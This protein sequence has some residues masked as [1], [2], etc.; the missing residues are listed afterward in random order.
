MML[1]RQAVIP[2]PATYSTILVGRMGKIH[3]SHV[4]MLTKYFLGSIAVL[5]MFSPKMLANVR[6]VPNVYATIS[7][8]VAAAS[9]G[10]TIRVFAGTYAEHVNVNKSLVL[11][12][13]G[14]Y[15]SPDSSHDDSGS[16]RFSD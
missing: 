14:T 10:D 2:K 1:P 4:Q 6:Y 11:I 12:G 7:A 3:F 13:S 5:A 8:A 15:A 16:E 9:S